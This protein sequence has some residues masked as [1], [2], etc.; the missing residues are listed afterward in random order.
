MYPN[1]LDKKKTHTSKGGREYDPT[2]IRYIRKHYKSTFEIVLT[3][4]GFSSEVDP[5]EGKSSQG[6]CQSSSPTGRQSR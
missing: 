6:F 1:K 4:L 3:N 2:Q 5:L